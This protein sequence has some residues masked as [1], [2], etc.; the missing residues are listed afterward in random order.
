VQADAA[1]ASPFPLIN[2]TESNATTTTSASFDCHDPPILGANPFVG[3]T[4]GQIGAALARVAQRAAVEPAAALATGL[5]AVADLVR[6]AV[7]RSDVEPSKGDRRF[8]DRAWRENPVLRRLLQ[9]Y[10]V[11]QR[12]VHRLVDEVKLDGTSRDR[13]HFAMSLLTEAASPTNNLLTNPNAVA[14]AAQTR[15]QSLV[16]GARHLAHDLRYNGGMPSQVDTR[17]SRSAATWPSRPGRWCTA[18][19]CSS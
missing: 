17:P 18:R 7:G 8:A 4:R 1:A 3:L 2:T 6:V 13:A 19:R 14:K 15:G 10:L 11:E 9:A 12:A 16:A 5:S